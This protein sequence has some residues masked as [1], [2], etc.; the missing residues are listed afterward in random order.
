MGTGGA[1]LVTEV[2]RRGGGGRWGGQRQV[3]P[4]A[5]AAETPELSLQTLSGLGHGAEQERT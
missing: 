5:V 3:F 4:A 2:Q 1:W